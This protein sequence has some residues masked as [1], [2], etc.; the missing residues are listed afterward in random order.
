[1]HPA[2]LKLLALEA[3]RQ[4]GAEAFDGSA[5]GLDALL[6]VDTALRQALGRGQR[7]DGVAAELVEL[8]HERAGAAAGAVQGRQ[9]EPVELAALAL[10][11]ETA[12]RIA[13]VFG[14]AAG[15]RGLARIAFLDELLHGMQAHAHVRLFDG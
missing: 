7:L 3:L 13:D 10:L 1:M 2:G 4:R 12:Q 8:G 15:E 6:V 11:V 14:L 5:E 9:Q